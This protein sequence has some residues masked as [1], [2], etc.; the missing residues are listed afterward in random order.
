MCTGT[1]THLL[2]LTTMNNELINEIINFDQKLMQGIVDNY[3]PDR[4]RNGLTREL[5]EGAEIIINRNDKKELIG[6]IEFLPK[7][8]NELYVSSLQSSTYFFQRRWTKKIFEYLTLHNEMTISSSVHKNNI[9]SINFHKKLGFKIVETGNRIRFETKVQDL[10][11]ILEPLYK[12]LKQQ[13][14]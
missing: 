1:H 10:L 12:E 3:D 14:I 7:D 8:N 4:R 13:Q 5:K 2:A 11:T 6:Y 9:Q